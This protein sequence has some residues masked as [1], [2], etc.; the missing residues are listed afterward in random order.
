MSEKRNARRQKV[1]GRLT[2][3]WRDEAGGYFK[4]SGEW[5]DLSESG[6]GIR[7]RQMIK[8]GTTVRVDSGLLKPAG[9]ARVRLCRQTAAGYRIGLEFL[10]GTR[11]CVPEGAG[12]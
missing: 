9:M 12:E 10:D 8:V 3:Q 7:M 5:L 1:T 11:G 4:E 6:G 2:V